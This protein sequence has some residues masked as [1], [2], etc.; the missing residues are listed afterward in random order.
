M[1]D[2]AVN[3]YNALDRFDKAIMHA[4]TKNDRISL[5][6]LSHEIGLT[7][8]RIRLRLKRLGNNRYI[9]RR[10]SQLDMSQPGSGR[11]AYVEVCLTNT[12]ETSLKEF[13]Y[14]VCNIEEIEQCHMMAANFDYLL[15]VCVKN[16]EAY[17]EVFGK[18]ISALPNVASMSTRMAMQTVK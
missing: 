18:K 12:S 17:R 8:K 2:F 10:C 5:S 1:D 16:M 4:V 6:E 9:E 7:E 14:A 3:K 13:N 11:V 15:K